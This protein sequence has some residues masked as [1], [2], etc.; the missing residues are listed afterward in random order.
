MTERASPGH[1]DRRTQRA[2]D[3]RRI[4]HAA[5]A[6]ADPRPAVDRAL[7]AAPELHDARCIHLLAIGKAAG[8]M[9]SAA[10]AGLRATGDG[11]LA[12]RVASALA[13]LP[14]QSDHE[15]DGRAG[16]AATP[17]GPASSIRILYAAHPYPDT[18]SARAAAVVEDMLGSTD[19]GDLVVVLISGGASSLCAAPVVGISID[20][21]S[22]VVR[23]LMRAGADIHELNTVRT[24][25][26]RL[27]GGGMARLIA[28]AH[29]LG[30]VMSDV[31][32]NHLDIIG[33]GPLTPSTTRSDDALRILRDFG[34]LDRIPTG[35]R[36]VL[37]H[38]RPAVSHDTTARHSTMQPFDPEE[39][40]AARV[41][42]QIILD[43][44]TAMDGAADEAR[45]MDYAVQVRNEPVTGI[46]HEAGTAIARNALTVAGAMQ[47]GDRPQCIISGGETTVEVRGTGTG[48]RNLELTLGA[49][50]A[51]EG[52]SRVTVASIGTDGVDGSSDAA[53][54]VADGAT[55]A[56]G[57]RAAINAGDALENNDSHTFF[58]TA[59]GLIRTG[60]TG[61]NV[62][63]VQIALIDPPVA[64]RPARLLIDPP[65]P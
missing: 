38:A 19:A 32:G 26:D 3:A 6:A 31:V 23:M 42:T 8:V 63:D 53:G 43:N 1:E 4:L 7:R 49:A 10:L 37:E 2:N 58:A 45:R 47:P 18:T 55:V 14:H 36:R 50:M 41:R 39:T 54:A 51:L 28:P 22:S 16:Q 5:I 29:A 56:N 46:A 35:V 30:L 62:M 15:G 33:S 24:H 48:G 65:G 52:D 60:P 59:G 61:T 27:K 17:A 12:D 64:D 57:K 9:A 44:H 40:G 11:A 34:L 25:I 21:Y 13:V 20:E